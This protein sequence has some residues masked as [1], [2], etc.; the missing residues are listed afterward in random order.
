M[1][2]IDVVDLN[3]EVWRFKFDWIP[4]EILGVQF[5]DGLGF[6]YR[7]MALVFPNWRD[8]LISDT[9]VTGMYRETR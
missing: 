3:G 1:Y 2:A 6:F 5:E 4:P 7:A 8:H 9:P